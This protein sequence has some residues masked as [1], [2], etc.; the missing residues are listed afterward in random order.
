MRGEERRG[1]DRGGEERRGHQG[2]AQS[3]GGCVRTQGALACGHA[4]LAL[5]EYY[6]LVLQYPSIALALP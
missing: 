6:T 5:P 1:A 3:D 4:I 2:R